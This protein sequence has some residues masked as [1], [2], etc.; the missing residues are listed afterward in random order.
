MQLTIAEAFRQPV[1]IYSTCSTPR[2]S[3][4]QATFSSEN[5]LTRAMKKNKNFILCFVVWKQK[6]ISNAIMATEMEWRA[7]QLWSEINCE[8]LKKV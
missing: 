5:Q 8:M 7:K 1:F 6:D 4:F 3:A 2:S